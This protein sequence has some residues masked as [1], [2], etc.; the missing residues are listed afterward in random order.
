MIMG[1]KRKAVRSR[2]VKKTVAA[3]K[4]R[5]KPLSLG[6]SQGRRAE[7]PKQTADPLKAEHD[8][9]LLAF[10]ELAERDE[11]LHDEP[12]PIEWPT[13]AEMA[14]AIGEETDRRN[15]RVIDQIRKQIADGVKFDGTP[16]T[17][18]APPFPLT[19]DKEWRDAPIALPVK[20][21]GNLWHSK[22]KAMFTMKTDK[23]KTHWAVGLGL[24]IAYG[25]SFC[26]W[27]AHNPATVLFIEGES[28]DHLIQRIVRVQSTAIGLT[29]NEKPNFHLLALANDRSFPFLN[30]DD[31]RKWL[32]AK[33]EEH[34]AQL[35][36]LDN[37][38]ALAP[39]L[40]S[41]SATAWIYQMM[42][43]L[44]TPLNHRGI[45]QLWLHHPDKKGKKQHGTGARTWGLHLDLFGEP[46]NIR[47]I[48]FNLR[49]LKKKDDDGT[50]YDFEDRFIGMEDGKWIIDEPRQLLDSPDDRDEP[51]DRDTLALAALQAVA[52][53]AWASGEMDSM[54]AQ[55]SIEFGISSSVNPASQK[56]AFRRARDSLR[57]TGQ[58]ECC[59]LAGEHFGQYRVAGV[60]A[61]EPKSDITYRCADQTDKPGW[62]RLDTDAEGN[63]S[64][65]GPFADE[66][67]A[68]KA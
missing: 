48:G 66:Q 33:I 13:A 67:T 49:Y 11:P 20:F 63:V 10:R 42:R 54:W 30:T 6:M 53:D 45:G 61:N 24:S 14:R 9:D 3:R 50:T 19:T 43:N 58:V 12:L 5:A 37:L 34:K 44:I 40:V 39:N 52:G 2:T 4:R 8:E 26:G 16:T 51:N 21:L 38:G 29:G 17:T 31:G 1:T 65:H 23:G 56:R 57:S 7:T 46:V 35:V 15:R 28:P 25:K 59:R 41:G 64:T 32:Y 62:Y 55:K 18:A 68:R 36:I 60:D 22:T 47:G 27:D